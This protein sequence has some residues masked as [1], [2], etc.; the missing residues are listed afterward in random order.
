MIEKV[1]EKP[2]PESDH[3]FSSPTT[4]GVEKSVPPTAVTKGDAAG[5]SG[6]K[7]WRGPSPPSLPQTPW[8][9]N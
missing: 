2:P 6:W 4:P 5:K 3:A 1:F 9:S 8:L 7:R